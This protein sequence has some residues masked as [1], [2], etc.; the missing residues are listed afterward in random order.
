MGCV[1]CIDELGHT[2]PVTPMNET[3]PV[4]PESLLERI[5]QLEAEARR[6]RERLGE[7]CP[8]A[9]LAP[10]RDE[11][12]DVPRPALQAIQLTH[13][14]NTGA[15]RTVA[16]RDVSLQIAAGEVALIM[17]P[18]GSGKSTLL[19]VLS[20]LLRP[21]HGQVLVRGTDLWGLSEREREAFRL[22]HFGFVF[23]GYNL[24]PTLTAREQLEMVVWWG[25]RGTRKEAARRAAEVLD[26]L[27]LGGKGDLL[28]GQLSGGEQQRVAIGRALIKEPDFCFVDEPTSALDWDHG[29]QVVQLLS[30][31]ARQRG[32]AV[33]VVAHDPRIAPYAHHVYRLEDGRLVR[34]DQGSGIRD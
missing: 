5:H 20:G 27:G 26:F 30:E 4:S 7:P 6:L 17:G 3:L 10:A 9:D 12:R 18:S 22:R 33:L 8:E 28:P 24:F 19:A 21:D 11:P 31:A 23:Q 13:S 2:F 15:V 25:E 16:L 14:F 34:R 32:A 29:K 1:A